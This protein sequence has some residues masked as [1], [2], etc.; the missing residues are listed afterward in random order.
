M[1]AAYGKF[2]RADAI[3]SQIMSDSNVAEIIATNLCNKLNT[4]VCIEDI[5]RVSVIGYLTKVYSLF[6]IRLI[7][8]SLLSV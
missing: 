6:S 7:C 8:E 3:D 5:L 1:C 4:S 2:F